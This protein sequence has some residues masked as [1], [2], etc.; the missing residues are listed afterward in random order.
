MSMY[1]MLCLQVT[2]VPNLQECIIRRAHENISGRSVSP[3]A[4]IDI[5]FMRFDFDSAHILH[6]IVNYA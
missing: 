3:T 6:K 5:I 1:V 2:D 4:T